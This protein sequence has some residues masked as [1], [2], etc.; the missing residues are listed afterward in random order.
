MI[1]SMNYKYKWY[2]SFFFMIV[3]LYSIVGNYYNLEDFEE[4]SNVVIVSIFIILIMIFQFL[5]LYHQSMLGDEIKHIFELREKQKR[6]LKAILSN[7]DEGLVIQ[8]IESKK[9]E[10][11][12]DF[13][14]QQL[15]ISMG[16]EML[17]EGE[18][19]NEQK[20]L[21][22]YDPKDPNKEQ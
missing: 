5:F 14:T 10:Y 15:T 13:I 20:I 16:K 19:W 8:D 3:L 17:P 21:S 11:K 1:V 12:N 18:Q 6:E 2:Y 7:I 22:E 9:F 4:V